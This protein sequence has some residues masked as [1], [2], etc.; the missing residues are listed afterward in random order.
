MMNLTRTR[1]AT[2]DESNMENISPELTEAVKQVGRKIKDIRVERGLSQADVAN[3]LGIRQPIISRIEKGTHVPT[4]R[5]L[6]RI[7]R[8]LGAELNVDVTLVALNQ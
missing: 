4:W 8:I 7:T 2:E 5:N 1:V 3:L 6:E